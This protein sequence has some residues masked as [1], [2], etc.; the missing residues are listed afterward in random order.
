MFEH[1]TVVVPDGDARTFA[2]AKSALQCC[3]E[4]PASALLLHAMTDYINLRI[5]TIAELEAGLESPGSSPLL[6]QLMLRMLFPRL[7]QCGS[8]ALEDG[9]DLAWW[10]R[11]LATLVCDWFERWGDLRLRVAQREGVPLAVAAD[12]WT[13]EASLE[14]RAQP[15]QS[16]DSGSAA[17]SGGEASDA[18]RGT[19]GDSDSQDADDDAEDEVDED[20]D[21][22]LEEAAAIPEATDEEVAEE[23]YWS[24]L[25]AGFGRKSPLERS[26]LFSDVPPQ[27]RARLLRCL[28]QWR[29]RPGDELGDALRAEASA[30]D[31]R[32]DPI[33]PTSSGLELILLPQFPLD[34]RIYSQSRSPGSSGLE[35]PEGFCLAA[36]NDGEADALA[37]SLATADLP[38]AD[39]AAARALRSRLKAMRRMRESVEAAIEE[40]TKEV[41][42]RQAKQ[43]LALPS[44]RVA[45]RSPRKA[46]RDYGIAS[47]AA[48]SLLEAREA[49]L[50][51]ALLRRSVARFPESTASLTPGAAAAASDEGARGSGALAGVGGGR[52]G[53]TAVLSPEAVW[54]AYWESRRADEE[55]RACLV[56]AVAARLGAEEARAVE[57]TVRE[58]LEDSPDL[59]MADPGVAQALT[60]DCRSRAAREL[61]MSESDADAVLIA[62]AQDS[63]TMPGAPHSQDEMRALRKAALLDE[64]R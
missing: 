34:V 26:A 53:G 6:D 23:K 41:Q 11:H 15:L 12:D 52:N 29:L 61:G 19:E 40:E 20:D 18:P 36:A 30:S 27:T 28:L 13:P 62:A 33:G 17:A 22:A 32:V 8:L 48:A 60:A 24:A 57:D 64:R 59:D 47:S 54:A 44:R 31:L 9:A 51:Q 56:A 1:D 55:A 58:A 3:W 46:L 35:A 39:R 49:A 21:Q 25:L 45:T 37:G 16:S 5:F 38:A 14:S 2:D 42:R 7:S 43:Q 63:A 10:S 4:V 50:E